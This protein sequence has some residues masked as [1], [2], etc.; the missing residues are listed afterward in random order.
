VTPEATQPAA[1]APRAAK[2][3]ARAA[4]SL[5]PADVATARSVAT[6]IV[7]ETG[8]VIVGRPDAVRM[9][10]YAML[11]NGH[12]LFE[13]VPGTAKT[14]LVKTIA[15]ATQLQFAR[16]QFTPDLLP[17]DI[18]GSYLFDMKNQ[19][20]VLRKGPLFAQIVLA[21]EVNRAPPKTQAALLEAMQERQVTLEGSTHPLPSPF[22]V[23]ATQNPI[24]SEGVYILPE[25]ELDRFMLRIS[26]GYPSE[27]EEVEVLARF[28]SWDGAAPVV[29]KAASPQ[30][31]DKAQAASRRVFVHP[32][33]KRYIAQIVHFT[34]RDPRVQVG[35]SPRG[36]IAIMSLAKA[37][38]AY[39]GR[40][41]ANADDVKEVASVAIAHRLLMR[42]E[43]A[44]RGA[45]PFQVVHDGL[46][47]VP[48][49]RVPTVRVT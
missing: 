6:R 48:T 33:L 25:A 35:S 49:P 8:K 10:V 12:I 40:D 1:A 37:A 31:L 3:V 21:D 22:L 29:G 26:M 30:Q 36:S 18:T 46:A 41:F 9:A 14:M 42:P 28:E 44:A 17:A 13:D 23:F 19:Q 47:K 7:E 16:V 15:Q 5:G 4:A 34:R 20:F 32:D 45:T 39:K 2:P 27:D 11:A 24:E 43:A 38:A